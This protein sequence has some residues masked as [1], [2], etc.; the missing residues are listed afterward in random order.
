MT[1]DNATPTP[2]KPLTDPELS[3]EITAM[4]VARVVRAEGVE[5]DR[6]NRAESVEDARVSR[7]EGVEDARVVRAEGVED[8]RVSRAEG[9]EDDRVV[10][11][12]SIEEDR[13]SRAGDMEIARI[14][15][16]ADIEADRLGRAGNIRKQMWFLFA[17]VL[18]AFVV[19]ALRTQQTNQSTQM[20]L[21][22]ACEKRASLAADYNKGREG[23]VQWILTN[24]ASQRTPE[25]R[26]EIARQLRDGLL[27]PVEECGVAP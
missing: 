18:V 2:V 10:R 6:V 3:R 20:G 22:M 13:L 27:L 4:K 7:A 9:V 25:Q 26:L 1:D 12:E 11:A 5:N 23:L 17:L 15:R 21:Y 19:L 16:A 14:G 24:P 8:D